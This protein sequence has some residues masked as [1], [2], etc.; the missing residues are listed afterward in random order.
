MEEYEII[1]SERRTRLSLC[2]LP[3]GKLQVRAPLG[4]SRS[5]VQRF[6]AAQ[7]PWIEERR[8]KLRERGM[9]QEYRFEAGEKFYF[10][11]ELFRLEITPSP[12]ARARIE[13]GILRVSSTA[14]DEIRLQLERFYR[15]RAREIMQK[16]CEPLAQKRGLPLTKITINSATTRW[17]SCSAGGALHFPWN[18]M[19]C[20]EEAIDYVAAHEVAHLE[21]MNHSDAFW[22]VVAELCPTW[23]ESSRF[24]KE[25]GYLFR[26]WNKE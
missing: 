16:K 18:L 21:E 3:D 11:G 13:P 2:M 8:K 6:V 14:P 9:P 4:M 1:F 5:A 25:E 10:L 20:P 22:R 15:A 7:K 26:A 23:E 19:M 24:L 12:A 17:G